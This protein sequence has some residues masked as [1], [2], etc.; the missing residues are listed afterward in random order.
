MEQAWMIPYPRTYNY[1]LWWP[2]LKNYSGE[3]MVGYFDVNFWT[4]YVW[5]DQ[6]LKKSMGY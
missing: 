4:P 6:N 2:W 1:T 5:I 3:Q